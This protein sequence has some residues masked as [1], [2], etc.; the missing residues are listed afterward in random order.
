MFTDN[1]I[2]NQII[3]L[4][5]K[6]E[7]STIPAILKELNKTSHKI[8]KAQ[9]Y[10][11]VNRLL[12]NH[13]VIKEYWFLMLNEFWLKKLERLLETVRGWREAIIAPG[14]HLLKNWDSK[15]YYTETMKDLDIKRS[16]VVAKIASIGEHKNIYASASHL[17]HVLWDTNLELNTYQYLLNSGWKMYDI[18]KWDS[19]LDEYAV[20]IVKSSP[21]KDNFIVKLVGDEPYIEDGLMIEVVW[22]Y[23]IETQVP[24]TLRSYF[25]QFYFTVKK[26]E[27]F[28]S[29]LFESIFTIR[30]DC[31]LKITRDAKKAASFKK[32]IRSYFK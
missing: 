21:V 5:A 28:D 23:I 3:Q 19:F 18:I 12:D 26:I 13:V 17:Y 29:E 7:K 2:D 14:H 4:L 6:K 20:N 11:I 8:S 10:K 22:D 27:D 15:V 30:S 9:L 24:E 32:K 25:K 1:K 16:D 31:R